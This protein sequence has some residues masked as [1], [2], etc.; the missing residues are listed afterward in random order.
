MTIANVLRQ[1]HGTPVKPPAGAITEVSDAAR[2]PMDP[3]GTPPHVDWVTLTDTYLWNYYNIPDPTRKQGIFHPSAG[4]HPE[5]SNCKRLIMFDLLMAKRS[6]LKLSAKL[7]RVLENGTN[8]HHGLQSMFANMAKH[9]W[10]GVTGYQHEVLA[11]HPTLPLSGRADGLIVMSSG[12]RYVH[13]YKT[14]G[15]DE[16]DKTYEPKFIHRCQINTYMGML[17]VRAGYMIY[18]NKKGQAWATPM[19]KF[20]VNFDPGLFSE[21][22]QYC[23]SIMQLLGTRQLPEYSEKTCKDNITFCAYEQVC[24]AHRSKVA[25]FDNIDQRDADTRRIHL[26]VIQ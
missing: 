19:P 11:I 17:G 9:R 21:V 25:T 14:I 18:E 22:E 2:W 3:G 4:L 23:Y 24:N 26:K 15:P 8:R 6:K 7:I 5:V 1:L 13:D 10:M 20:R 16:F 12:H